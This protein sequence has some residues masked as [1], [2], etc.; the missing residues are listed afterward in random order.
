MSLPAWSV[1]TQKLREEGTQ[2]RGAVWVGYPSPAP[3]G[4]QVPTG[5]EGLGAVFVFNPLIPRTL[6]EGAEE[7]SPSGLW[8]VL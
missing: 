7:A 8:V 6:K 3:L 4:V 5:K 1:V 2:Q